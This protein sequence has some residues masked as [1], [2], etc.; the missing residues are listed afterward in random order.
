MRMFLSLL[1]VVIAFFTI[2]GECSAEMV[3][4]VRDFSDGNA[5]G[6]ETDEIR[7]VR[8]QDS[9]NGEPQHGFLVPTRI[10]N[11]E[12][13]EILEYGWHNLV[14]FKTFDGKWCEA[15]I[16]KE[17]ARMAKITIKKAMVIDFN[18]QRLPAAVFNVLCKYFDVDSID[19][20]EAEY[21]SEGNGG[22]I[23]FFR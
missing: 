3:C 9:R 4:V 16:S 22:T 12:S 13:G 21:S 10:F 8:L 23:A 5:L 15:N 20:T 2:V 18:I 7:V 14:F 19:N 17:S 1:I 6:V 11:P